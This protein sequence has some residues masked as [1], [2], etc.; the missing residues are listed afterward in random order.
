MPETHAR[1]EQHMPQ[2]SRHWTKKE[3]LSGQVVLPMRIGLKQSNLD[4]GHE[5]LM[6]MYVWKE[7][8]RS[9]SVS[10]DWAYGNG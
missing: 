1:H 6:E 2:V 3:K 10:L 7:H 5:R 4:A 9:A 8:I